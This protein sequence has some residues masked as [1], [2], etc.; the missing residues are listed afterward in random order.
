MQLVFSVK[1]S[2]L[3]RVASADMSTSPDS[4]AEWRASFLREMT[5]GLQLLSRNADRWLAFHRGLSEFD[6]G[7]PIFQWGWKHFIFCHTHA[8]V[9]ISS[10]LAHRIDSLL[11]KCSAYSKRVNAE[12]A[13]IVYA[14]AFFYCISRARVGEVWPRPF[15]GDSDANAMSQT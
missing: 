4:C 14:L 15:H 2:Q 11:K 3:Q 10:W 12:F 1:G 5:A 13:R 7:E 9:K 6:L 8:G